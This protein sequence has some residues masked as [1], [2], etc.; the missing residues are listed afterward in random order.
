MDIT[1]AELGRIRHA[2]FKAHIVNVFCD[3][4]LRAQFFIARYNN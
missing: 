2:T 4:Y 1:A 3:M